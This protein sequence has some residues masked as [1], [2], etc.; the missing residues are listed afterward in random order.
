MVLFE[1]DCIPP[2][3]VYWREVPGV[4]ISSAVC[5]VIPSKMKSVVEVGHVPEAV[6]AIVSARKLCGI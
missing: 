5:C 1:K 2:E 4:I 3:S 6:K